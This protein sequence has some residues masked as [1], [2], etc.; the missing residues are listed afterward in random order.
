MAGTIALQSHLRI[1]TCVGLLSVLIATIAPAQVPEF[2]NPSADPLV[3]AAPSGMRLRPGASRQRVTT[4]NIVGASL[5]YQ[6]LDPPMFLPPVSY[7]LGGAFA[8]GIA[9]ADLN[10]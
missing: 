9:V 1:A 3:G 10:N 5:P 8:E 2:A 4:P 7:P 6:S